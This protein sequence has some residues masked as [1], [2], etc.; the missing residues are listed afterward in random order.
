MAWLLQQPGMQLSAGVMIRAALH[1]H[2]ALC[3]YLHEQQ[4]PCHPKAASEAAYGRHIDLLRWLVDNGCPLD[5]H[6]VCTAA[7]DGGSIEVLQYLQQQGLMT[8]TALLTEMLDCAAHINELP[9]AKWLRARSR[10]AY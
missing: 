3:Q 6:E 4:C 1:G 7:A 2:A 8:S 10:M 9:A 5:E